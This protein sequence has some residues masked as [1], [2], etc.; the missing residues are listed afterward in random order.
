MKTRIFLLLTLF[1]LMIGALSFTVLL[2]RSEVVKKG[3]KSSKLFSKS[4]TDKDTDKNSNSEIRLNKRDSAA[5]KLQGT[6]N[7]SES[8]S[9]IQNKKTIVCK[10]QGGDMETGYVTECLYKNY[11]LAEA[12]DAFRKSNNSNDDGKYLE[13]Q[14]PKAKHIA[15][16]EECPISVTYTYPKQNMLEL[17]LLFPG[18]VTIIKFNDEKDKV[19][20][21]VNHSPD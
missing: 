5:H 12:Y 9:E 20:V 3:Y 8:Q 10:D 15:S 2:S 16:F 18:G 4:A 11:N 13:K 1:I 6:N 17:E 21:T 14:M 7:S 19:I